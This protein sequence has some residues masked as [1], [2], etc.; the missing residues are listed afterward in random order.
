VEL[1]NDLIETNKI[2]GIVFDIS[3]NHDELTGNR[4]IDVV[5][6]TLINKIS[7]ARTNFLVCVSH[8]DYSFPKNYSES[9]AKIDMYIEPFDFNVNQAIRKICKIIGENNDQE[10]KH[11]LILTD[12]FESK[13]QNSYKSAFFVKSANHYDYKV[14]YCSIGNN[15]DHDLLRKLAEKE[16][17]NFAHLKNPQELKNYLEKFGEKNG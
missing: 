17:A 12:R 5:K 7:T 15:S 10:E 3:I 6:K 9:I 16:G 2:I 13:L 11:I 8:K 14:H 1:F 4:I